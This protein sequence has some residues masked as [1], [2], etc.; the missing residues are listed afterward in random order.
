MTSRCRVG[1]MLSSSFTDLVKE[2]DIV[3]ALMGRNDFFDIAME[4]DAA[5]PTLDKIDSSLHMVDRAE[6]FVCIIGYRYGTPEFDE[7]RNPEGLSLTE[8]EWRRARERGIPR[9]IL[10]MS[11]DYPVPRARIGT[12]TPED[13]QKLAAFRALIE[14]DKVYAAFDDESDLQIKAMQ[15]LGQLRRDLE[16]LDTSKGDAPIA[17]T[18]SAA[19]LNPDEIV[20]TAAPELHFVR[21]SYIQRQRFAGRNSELAQ[22][23]SW[24]N[25]NDAMLVFQAIGGMGKSMLTWHWLKTRAP[26]VRTDW[27]GRYWY[28]FYEQGADLNDFC[29]HALAYIRHQP[30]ARFRGQRTTD[31]GHE[32]RRDLDTKPWL[33]VLDGLERVLVAYNAADKETKADDDAS[34]SKDGLGIDREPRRCFQPDDDDVLA[35]LAQADLGKLL[36]S[37]RLMPAA[38]TNRGQQPIPGVSL[39][40]LEGLAPVDAE[41]VMRDAGNRGDGLRI[42]RFLDDNF[43]C[44]PLSVAVVAGEVKSSVAA[45]GDFDKWVEDPY[46][47][48]DPALLAKDLRGRQNHILSRAFDGLDKDEKA[49]L[50]AIAMVNFDLSMDVLRAINPK[51][52]IEPKRVMRPKRWTEQELYFITNSSVVDRAYRNWVSSMSTPALRDKSYRVLQ[53]HLDRDLQDRSKQYAAYEEMH[54]SWTSTVAE[55]NR[56]LERALP[57]LE[58]RGL[59]QFEESSGTLDMHPAIRHTAMNSLSADAR[60]STGAHLSDALSSRPA[61]PLA[62]ARS[63][64]D[65][66]L[67]I[68]RVQALSAAGMFDVGWRILHSLAVVL[69]RL[70]RKDILAEL[71]QPYFPEGWTRAPRHIAAAG[72]DYRPFDWAA[73]ALQNESELSMRLRVQD[74][75]LQLSKGEVSAVVTGLGVLDPTDADGAPTIRTLRLLTLAKR[76]ADAVDDKWHKAECAL[77]LAAFYLDC[78]NL[79]EVHLLLQAIRPE[80]DRI[81]TSDGLRAFLA[82]IDVTLARRNGRLRQ[83]LIKSSLEQARLDGYVWSE[84]HILEQ[85][86]GWHQDR[87]AHEEALAIYESLIGLVST[88]SARGRISTYKGR[89][90]QSLIALDRRDEALPLVSEFE[91][92]QKKLNLI[93][94]LHYL[95]L[96]NRDKAREHALGAYKIC[97]GDGP[98]YH[99]HWDMEECRGVLAAL[100]EPEPELPSCDPSTVK[101]YD[102][103]VDVDRLI[104]KIE[105]ERSDAQK[106]EDG[107]SRET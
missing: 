106:G 51:C 97:W 7:K 83:S 62:E 44:H 80:V 86:A 23:D 81:S 74:L 12:V 10:V 68:T 55:A 57:A 39:I 40:A 92:E 96:G 75:R 67:P 9:F 2:R 52:P 65:L 31:L 63:L 50:G 89:R 77:R 98:P 49:L 42:Q 84:R 93:S 38:L 95:A 22:L 37:S 26:D 79:P 29:V 33:L 99:R 70:E 36:A 13:Q 46:G 53:E 61:I 76:L 60:T 25:S 18:R 72:S 104:A 48:S 85:A 19:P 88:T 73:D 45:R 43:A 54:R 6:A 1:L 56:W 82:L 5:L 35:M 107:K 34:V 87:G 101:P 4:N 58:A 14:E 15:S 8:L 27:A 17:K 102:F 16:A 3:R 78:G 59:L 66:S 90:I 47:G 71:L 64:S 103:E 20:P 100:G 30:P 11:D 21:K 28:S 32:L 69:L 41:Q 24:A 91:Q 105:A 94:A